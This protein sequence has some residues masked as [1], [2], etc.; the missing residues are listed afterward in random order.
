[1]AKKEA[2][3][4]EKKT[5]VQEEKARAL[6]AARLQIEKQ[7]GKG[8]LMKLGE[9]TGRVD[10]DVIPT[11][12]IL[13][14]AAVGVG[15]Y[16]R[17]RVVEIY[18][19]ES[20]GKTTLALHAIAESQKQGGIAAFV[21][22]EHALDPVYAKNLGVNVDELWVSQPDTGEQALE[23]VESLVRSGAVDII[24]VDS[25][26]ALTPRA[27][28]EGDMGDSHMGLQ[29]R[30]MSQ[31]LRKLT[32]TIS[33]TRTCLIFI[34]QIR[35]KIG[36]MFG[37][38]ETTTGGFA[39]KFY[40]SLRLEVR[41]VESISHG[42]EEVVGNK[43]RVKVVKN[44][45]APPF[46]KAEMDIMFG[47]GISA[48]GSLLEAAIQTSIVEKAGSWYSYGKERI[49]Q[50]VENAR[51]FLESNPTV[52]KDVEKKVREILFAK[53]DT[54]AP[55]A[56]RQPAEGAPALEPAPLQ[57]QAARSRAPASRAAEAATEGGG[58]DGGESDDAS[59]EQ[60]PGKELF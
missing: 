27:E 33:K 31:A 15:G 60:D 43:V 41:K 54:T 30:L 19:P 48:V 10:I 14:D 23:I 45:V 40:S 53:P 26:A 9:N 46:R 6:E 8:S 22:A 5:A 34:N 1:M 59:G 58:E 11:G 36:V 57:P 37:N 12:S 56:A 20:S 3:A 50:G 38:P 49:G 2:P 44:K 18:G 16:P 4:T 52:Y 13:L 55:G 32:G 17:G 42:N 24:V 25:V 39:L 35:M 21:D 47:K 29:A 51:L 7:F 28:I